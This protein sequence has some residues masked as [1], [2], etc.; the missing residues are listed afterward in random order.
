M[1]I[2]TAVSSGRIRAQKAEVDLAFRAVLEA[3]A[4]HFAAS[5]ARSG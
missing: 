1:G 4:D 2:L 3:A 5:I